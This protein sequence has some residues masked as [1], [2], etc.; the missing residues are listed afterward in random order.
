VGNLFDHV[1]E[2][3]GGTGFDMSDVIFNVYIN[4]HRVYTERPDDLPT[5]YYGNYLIN[6]GYV[7]GAIAFEE[8][9]YAYCR[10][11]TMENSTTTDGVGVYGIGEVYIS[12]N[13]L[14]ES[15]CI[16]TGETTNASVYNNLIIDGNFS[17]SMKLLGS[18]AAW[19][20]IIYNSYA[21]ELGENFD[22]YCN[23]TFI[24]NIDGYVFSNLSFQAEV[25]N[26]ILYTNHETFCYMN[27]SQYP[28]F[29]NNWLSHDISSIITDGG[30]NIVGD[31][32]GLTDPANGDFS[33]A[34]GSPCIDAGVSDSLWFDFDGQNYFRIADGDGDGVAEIDIGAWERASSYRGCLEGYVFREDGV[35]PLDIVK[36]N[37]SNCLPEWSDSTGYFRFDCGP[38]EFTLTADHFY[39]DAQTVG[40]YTVTPGE[41]VFVEVTMTGNAVETPEELLQPYILQSRN[42]PNPFNPTTTISFSIPQDSHVELS[43]YNIRGQLVKRLVNEP[44]EAGEHQV[45]WDGRNEQ[46]RTVG[47]G[48]YFY[49]VSAGNRSRVCK[50]MLLK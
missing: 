18:G 31:D 27:Q 12:D 4:T 20:N 25:R 9:T 11:N 42:Y 10:R 21:V 1:G 38:G 22:L 8:D 6:S 49:R 48:V 19:N 28:L 36:L 33:L 3:I 45:V 32:P 44:L 39:Y 40:T 13:I 30:G 2:P 16:Y 41:M 7:I 47:S 37:L 24:G 43:V 26:N 5:N 23:N 35:T 15:G 50:M 29:R 46:D 14:I 34:E 17:R